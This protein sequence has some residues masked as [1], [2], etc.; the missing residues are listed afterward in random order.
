[1]SDILGSLLGVLDPVGLLHNGGILAPALGGG[2]GKGLFYK[3]KDKAK[4]PK[5][6]SRSK[7]TTNRTQNR[8]DAVQD[9][10]TKKLQTL[11]AQGQASDRKQDARLKSGEEK[12]KQQD[13][14]HDTLSALFTAHMKTTRKRF[15]SISRAVHNVKRWA[16]GQIAALQVAI[17]V[18]AEDVNE[19]EEML[20]GTG[21]I[22]PE[23]EDGNGVNFDDFDEF[24][25]VWIRL[26]GGRPYAVDMRLLAQLNVLFGTARSYYAEDCPEERKTFD[27]LASF[28]NGSSSFT[29]EV[30]HD[31]TYAEFV[32]GIKW[33]RET[34]SMLHFMDT[35]DGHITYAGKFAM[36]SLTSP[37]DFLANYETDFVSV[38]E[39]EKDG[40]DYITMKYIGET[41]APS[42]GPA[43]RVIEQRPTISKTT[44]DIASSIH[45]LTNETVWSK[46][47]GFAGLAST[48][49]GGSIKE[50]FGSRAHLVGKL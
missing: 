7:R 4:R 23:M 39:S 13:R 27:L 15:R 8:T 29:Q 16:R 1:M 5:R 21:M 24:G 11:A 35:A 12:D 17:G 18:V 10:A 28:K 49:F 37:S 43:C 31:Y 41:P 45:Y 19:V 40:C 22:A 30:V 50:L 6:P 44:I 26:L 38:T 47:G 2:V 36:Y 34:T 48:M 3:E 20:L 32:A 25:K 42:H 9:A 14:D 46:F 33:N